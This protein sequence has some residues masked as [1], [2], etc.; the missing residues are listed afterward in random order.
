MFMLMANRV[1]LDQTALEQSD[2][3]VH[4]LLLYLYVPILSILGLSISIKSN[5]CKSE[6]KLYSTK[7]FPL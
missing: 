6:K 7:P 4:C 2:R 1:H 5:N 3:G